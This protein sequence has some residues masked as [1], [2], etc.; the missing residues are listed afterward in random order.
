M[1]INRKNLPLL[2]L[3]A[4]SVLLAILYFAWIRPAQEAAASTTQKPPD[5]LSGEDLHY[6]NRVLIPY[7]SREKMLSITVHNENGEFRFARMKDG[8]L[9]P[10]ESFII[11]IR[12]GEEFRSYPHVSYNQESFASLV[13][14][15]GTVY[16]QD[17]IVDVT[18]EPERLAEYGLAE[19]DAPAWFEVVYREEGEDGAVATKTVRIIVGDA[20]VTGGGYYLRRAG[21]NDVYVSSVTRTGEAALSDISAYVDPVLA[22]AHAEYGYYYDRAF[23]LF[24]GDSLFL[25]IDF[26]NMSRRDDFHAGVAYAIVAPDEMRAYMPNSNN[27]MGVLET[28]G[29]LEGSTTVAVG[30]AAN[31]A[32]YGLSAYRIYYETPV[33]AE[34]D[35]VYDRDVNV[36]VY[37]PNTLYISEKQEDGSYFVGSTESDIIARV[38]GE[39]MSF[40]ERPLSWWLAPE[41]FAVNINNTERLLF[42]FRYPD[43]NRQ[44]ELRLTRSPDGGKYVTDGVYYVYEEDGREMERRLALEAYQSLHMNLATIRYAGLYDGSLPVGELTADDENCKLILS[45]TMTD[46]AM[47][48]YRFYP[49]TE[50]HILVSLS[51]RGGEA[52]AWFYITAD[53]TEKLYRDLELILSGGIP[54]PDKRY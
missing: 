25:S 44:Y 14:G 2:L 9:T 10:G 22:S 31:R 30:L 24:Y 26:L 39:K 19:G 48:E 16:V 38:D 27:Y 51:E 3:A 13:V 34:S 37:T 20:A 1:K 28:V 5:T 49:Y 21:S 15:V 42:S 29:T 54:N 35:E 11:E 8:E 18:D 17:R 43:V 12:E 32:R 47:F 52:G 40:L 50:R 45:L 6:G 46:G 7:I 36:N 23:S 4:L 53:E 41:M 33:S